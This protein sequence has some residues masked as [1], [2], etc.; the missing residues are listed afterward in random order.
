MYWVTGILG[1]ILM[2]APFY[3]GYADISSAYWA[4]FLLGAGTI[5]LSIFEW[6]DHALWEYGTVTV[7]GIMAMAAPFML[8]FGNQESALW[9]NMIIGG[10]ITLFA[11]TALTINP[12]EKV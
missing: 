5:F 10:L 6:A 8:G 7:L 12:A 9:T 2:G 3:F 1:L 11:G 4:S